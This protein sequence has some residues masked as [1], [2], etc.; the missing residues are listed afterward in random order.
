MK[1][2]T[3]KYKNRQVSLQFMNENPAA[4]FQ[5]LTSSTVLVERPPVSVADTVTKY[6]PFSVISSPSV[7]LWNV[8][9]IMSAAINK[10]QD[11]KPPGT[12]IYN[13]TSSLLE[14]RHPGW[15][16]DIEVILCVFMAVLCLFVVDL[17]LFIVVLHLCCLYV[18]HCSCFVSLLLLCV[19]MVTL[20]LLVVLLHHFV[21]V[22]C[23]FVVF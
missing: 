16:R 23:F 4:G 18:F 1:I 17:C 6:F 13:P 21:I 5:S 7:V 14:P 9:E 8:E 3:K 11:N 15:K 12:D 20:H 22:L 10:L 2:C 19:F